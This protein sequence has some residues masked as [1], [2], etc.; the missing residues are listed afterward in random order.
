METYPDMEFWVISSGEGRYLRVDYTGYWDDEQWHFW[1]YCYDSGDGRIHATR[2]GVHLK[3][4]AVAFDHFSATVSGITIGQHWKSEYQKSRFYIAQAQLHN[5]A[6]TPND[7]QAVSRDPFAF[8]GTVM[9]NFP[10]SNNSVSP[11]ALS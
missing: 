4:T 2:D 5:R 11:W 1:G 9:L 6:F 7:F 3:S 8:N 10:L